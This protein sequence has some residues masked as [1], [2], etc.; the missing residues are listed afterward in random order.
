MVG[1]SMTR[2]L[3]TEERRLQILTAARECLLERGYHATRVE[4]IARTAGLSKGAVYF[5]FENKRALLE[6]LVEDEFARAQAIFADAAASPSPLMAMAGA[7]V[8]FLGQPG[9]A[10]HRFFVL[11]GALAVEDID[12]RER[13]RTHHERLLSRMADVFA[14]FARAAGR[15]LPDPS[16]TAVLVKAMADGLQGAFAMGFEFDRARLLTAGLTLLQSGLLGA[17]PLATLSGVAPESG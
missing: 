17:D 6:A 8:A 15:P 2:H 14:G 1:R 16:A 7:F 4:E 13:L 11:T 12:L 10:R 5:H 3:P 9:D